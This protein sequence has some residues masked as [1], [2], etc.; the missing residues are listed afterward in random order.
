[1]EGPYIY[2]TYH[3]P[4]C[5]SS[6]KRII[7]TSR[8]LGEAKAS[9]P[10]AREG[11]STRAYLTPGNATAKHSAIA[12]DGVTGKEVVLSDCCGIRA[13]R[14]DDKHNSRVVQ[15][16]MYLRGTGEEFSRAD[17]PTTIV[18]CSSLFVGAIQDGP[19]TP[20]RELSLT[21]CRQT[22]RTKKPRIIIACSR[23]RRADY[24]VY[25]TP[26]EV[27]TDDEYPSSLR[28]PKP[29]SHMHNRSPF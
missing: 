13:C 20:E 24:G 14:S 8:K 29:H 26:V 18:S 23:R 16:T 1:M 28:E 7:S 25:R 9:C 3:G 6:C 15:H 12:K 17:A 21:C 10:P 11:Y 19:Y 5:E 22:G 2:A 4:V 27:G